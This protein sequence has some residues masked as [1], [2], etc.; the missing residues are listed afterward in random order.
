MD[1]AIRK[2]TVV[3][4]SVLDQYGGNR[5]TR[6][7]LVIR[8]SDGTCFACGITS[9]VDFNNLTEYQIKLPF[10]AN[11]NCKTGLKKESVVCCDWITEIPLSECTPC[12]F[13]P[14]KLMVPI[15]DRVEQFVERKTGRSFAT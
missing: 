3:C 10:N 2:S 7:N 14:M 4:A 11:G 5:K 15:M 8:L 13:V 6:F 9:S 12:G 1:G